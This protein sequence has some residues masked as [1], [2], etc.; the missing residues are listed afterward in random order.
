VF[1]AGGSDAHGD[2]NYR[3]EGAVFGWTDAIDSAIGK[4]RNLV[5]VGLA[6]PKTIANGQSTVAQ[7]QVVDG[8]R[9]GNFVVTDGPI[10]RVAL[11]VNNSGLIDDGDVPM[12]GVGDLRTRSIPLLVEWKSTAEFGPVTSVDIFVG[13]QAGTRDG[14]V[15]APAGAGVRG[16][17][18][19]LNTQDYVNGT[20]TYH[21]TNVYVDDRSG[22]LRIAVPAGQGYGGVTKVWL[23]R[24]DYP[25]FDRACTT[26]T[27]NIPPMCD[28]RHHCT[29]PSS[30]QVYHC[31]ASNLAAPERVF[32]RAFV[33][34]SGTQ[35]TVVGTGNVS[36]PRFGYSN[37]VWVR[38][39]PYLDPRLPDIEEGGVFAP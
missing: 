35:V 9:S 28:A 2:L 32:L 15:Y 23:S 3:R 1:M 34:T 26:E 4:P 38:P 31:T 18:D 21:A 16:Q 20:A 33:R 27:I 13:S 10:V 8:L 22:K 29:K 39:N 37:P 30:Y 11:D 5:Y 6:R 17:F 19:G 24:A 25:V 7:S 36:I 14:V 12:G